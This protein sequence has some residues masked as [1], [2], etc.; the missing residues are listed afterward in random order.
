MKE[1]SVLKRRQVSVGP[2]GH[3]K[4]R[5]LGRRTLFNRQLTR[6]VRRFHQP[7]GE[8]SGMGVSNSE[9]RSS[10]HAHSLAPAANSTTRKDIPKLPTCIPMDNGRAMI[11]AATT[12]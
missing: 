9:G 2:A 11:P 1:S 7:S 12:L 4:G 5:I 6:G 3:G 10:S 8:T